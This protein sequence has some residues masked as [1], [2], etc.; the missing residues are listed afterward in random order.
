MNENP[1]TIAPA[2]RSFLSTAALRWSPRELP[3]PQVDPAFE[4]MNQVQ[5][6]V[7]VLRY[8]ALQFEHWVSSGGCLREWLRWNTAVALF[9]SIPAVLIIPVITSLLGQ[10]ATWSALIKETASNLIIFPI[11]GIIGIALL[12]AIALLIR[13]ILPR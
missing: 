7:E 2:K 3:I 8:S 6:T 13:L 11:T 9:L 4:Q 1:S 12:S 5:R 10:F